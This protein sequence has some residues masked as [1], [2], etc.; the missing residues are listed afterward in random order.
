VEQSQLCLLGA[1]AA[2]E[3]PRDVQVLDV[4]HATWEHSTRFPGV[5]PFLVSP[6]TPIA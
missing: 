6:G 4:G 2:V 3:N 5:G 1:V